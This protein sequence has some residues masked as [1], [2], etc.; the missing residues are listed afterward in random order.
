MREG[1][2]AVLA[3]DLERLGTVT[4]ASTFKMH[5]V[6]HTTSPC[7][8]YWWPGTVACLHAV[9]ELR[10]RGVGA[11]ATMDAG[12]QVKVLCLQTDAAEVAG[13]L[14]DH[15]LRVEVLVPGGGA[16]LVEP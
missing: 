4:E 11:W 13:T 9:R 3:R 15:A 2:E 1:R 16:R 14:A 5:A 6:M 10:S 7:L 8:L 12:P